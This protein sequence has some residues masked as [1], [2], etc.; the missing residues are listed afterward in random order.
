MLHLTPTPSGPTVV[1]SSLLDELGVPHAFATRHGG[2]SP[3][4]T[5]SLNFGTELDTPQNIRANT[6]RLLASVGCEGRHWTK[7]QQVHG[8]LCHTVRLGLPVGACGDA[9]VTDDPSCLLAIRTAD[10]VPI[11]IAEKSGKVVA[12]VH[13][14]W[15]G[16]VAGVISSAV[17]VMQET[18]GCSPSELVAAVGPCIGVHHFE[19][20]HE[21]ARA[22]GEINLQNVINTSLGPKPHVDLAH[23]CESQ[24]RSLGLPPAG[25]DRADM[26]TYHNAD[27]FFSHRRDAG[28]TGRMA[29]VIGPA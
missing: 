13:A 21:V 20:G 16:V 26:C 22:F 9:L 24:L 28:K 11:L 29:N 2:V 27:L 15:R 14:G 1:R 8:H 6:E 3:S 23:A 4:P 10:C 7:V 12:A 25:V 5:D 19:V 17:K 18:F